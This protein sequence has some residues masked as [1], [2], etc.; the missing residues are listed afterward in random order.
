M[1]KTNQIQKNRVKT[2]TLKTQ[3]WGTQIQRQVQKI[4]SKTNS[5]TNSKT[6]KQKLR[7]RRESKDSPLQRHPNIQAMARRD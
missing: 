7:Q 6:G 1:Q 3:G 5:K 2:P 4:S